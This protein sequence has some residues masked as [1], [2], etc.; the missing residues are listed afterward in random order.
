MWKHRLVLAGVLL[1]GVAATALVGLASIRGEPA[2]QT[3]K[4]PAAKSESAG[5][6]HVPRSDQ[7]YTMRLSN[8]LEVPV[9]SADPQHKFETTD[10]IGETP[11]L[12]RSVHYDPKTLELDIGVQYS[13][14]PSD[15]EVLHKQLLAKYVEAGHALLNPEALAITRLNPDAYRLIM[16]CDKQ[17]Y[18]LYSTDAS[19]RLSSQMIHFHL[20]MGG[21]EAE[22]LRH[23][24]S[25]KL[26]TVEL[27]LRSGVQWE[28]V[29]GFTLERSALKSSWSKV[30]EIVRPP[31]GKA[32]DS[33]LVVGRIADQEV[34]RLFADKVE[35]DFRSW[36]LT[37]EE[38]AAFLAKA[39]ED[40]K[41]H[42]TA[43]LTIGELLRLEQDAVVW[44]VKAGKIEAAPDT[45]NEALTELHELR[46]REAKIDQFCE[47]IS[48]LAASSSSTVSDEKFHDKASRLLI[49]ANASG[50]Y[51][52][53]SA[54]A[55]LHLD[56]AWSDVEK[57]SSFKQA[58]QSSAH[59][60]ARRRSCEAHAE[61]PSSARRRG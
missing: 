23:M 33:L 50:S 20:P 44:D 53:F 38:E 42:E 43:P 28:R 18:E 14:F 49:D 48:D 4:P 32:S 58:F 59:I 30:S 34:R 36:G 51:I 52:F 39:R 41:T 13:W 7:P 15:E 56:K 46:S 1:A 54:E 19:T 45:I 5:E 12:I 47:K 17:E 60:S 40:I 8:G 26:E 57:N 37:T 24:L 25:D 11:L 27:V 10:W 16:V 3:E 35:F 29:A 6:R 31:D 9:Y 22:N 55:G 21:P 2:R 61:Q